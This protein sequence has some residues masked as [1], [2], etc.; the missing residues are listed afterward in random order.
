MSDGD[1]YLRVAAI[2]DPAIAPTLREWHALLAQTKREMPLVECVDTPC[3]V[4]RGA[5]RF[6]YR[7]RR[8]TPQR[9]FYALTKGRQLDKRPVVS[10]CGRLDCV[11][12]VVSDQWRPPKRTYSDVVAFDESSKAPTPSGERDLNDPTKLTRAEREQR[13]ALNVDEMYA[14]LSHLE[15]TGQTGHRVLDVAPATVERVAKRARLDDEAERRQ[16]NEM[17]AR[18]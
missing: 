4:W 3:F 14:R 15:A 6:R 16:L 11:S 9:L 18:P 7:Q 5:A 13:A 12:H 1:D 8:W 17:A 10:A 2:V